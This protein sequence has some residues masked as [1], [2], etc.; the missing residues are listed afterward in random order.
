ME[1]MR[2]NVT[3]LGRMKPKHFKEQ[4]MAFTQKSYVATWKTKSAGSVSDKRVD[5]TI[6][7]SQSCKIVVLQ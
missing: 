6:I 2:E 3:H 4:L 1:N 5:R 7:V